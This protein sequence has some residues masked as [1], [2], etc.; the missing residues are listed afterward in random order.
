MKNKA[1]VL[2]ANYYVGLSIIRCLGRHNIHVTVVDYK[3]E[4]TYGL[5]SKYVSEQL[6]AP[7]YKEDTREYIDFLIEY[8]KKQSC[9]PCF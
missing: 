8:A 1:V 6:I 9:K 3:T 4:G 7:H 2:G 5:R